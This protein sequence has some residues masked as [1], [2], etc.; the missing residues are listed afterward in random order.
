MQNNKA[1]YETRVKNGYEK[2]RNS[3][4]VIC[5]LVRDSEAALKQNIPFVDKLAEKFAESTIFI[6]ENDSV[7]NTKMLLK[8]W[9]AKNDSVVIDSRDYG[10]QTIAEPQKN[11]HPRARYFSENRISKMAGFRN[12]YMDYVKSNL[13]VD[14]LIAIDLDVY[15]IS[16]DGIA[17]SFGFEK[18]WDSINSN[19]RKI[20]PESPFSPTFYDTFA[21]QDLRD[22]GP[23]SMKSIKKYQEKYKGL[24]TG[25]DLI[26][27]NSGFNGMAIYRWEAIK[28]L[29]YR[30]EKNNDP[31][32]KY[33]C[34]HTVFHR[35]MRES[36]NGEIY[37]NPSQLVNYEKLG[38]KLYFDKIKNKLKLKGNG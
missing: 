32:V 10:T 35:E 19:G 24:K 18:K 29:E 23:T 21:F 11:E 8:E 7:D 3:S 27:V 5:A 33:T 25:M 13:K 1:L 2:M 26:K 34:E 36:G 38:P 22:E 12:I 15:K 20:T 14:Y 9:G 16:L 37:L 6:V 4:V 28:E 31:I 17:S 30:T